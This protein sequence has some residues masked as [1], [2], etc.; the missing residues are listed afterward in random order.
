MTSESIFERWICM[1]SW[2]IEDPKRREEHVQRRRRHVWGAVG[3][4]WWKTK[5]WG[6]VKFGKGLENTLI[7]LSSQPLQYIEVHRDSTRASESQTGTGWLWA[8]PKKNNYIWAKE[9]LR[10]REARYHHIHSLW[11]F[12]GKSTRRSTQ[13]PQSTP[14]SFL[15]S[16]QIGEKSCLLKRKENFKM[17]QKWTRPIMKEHESISFLK[18]K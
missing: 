17:W 11:K 4:Q 14:Q 10:S 3:L 5:L 16:V 6:K 7:S 9:I 18:G 15:R 8:S 2:E 12:A 1:G 13:M